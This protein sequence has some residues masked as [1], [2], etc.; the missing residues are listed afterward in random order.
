VE[1]RERRRRDYLFAS[2]DKLM[3]KASE[4][5]VDTMH[6]KTLVMGPP[7]TGKTRFAATWP[8]GNSYFFD[9]DGNMVTVNGAKNVFYDTFKDAD[10][11][12]PTAFQNAQKV[13]VEMVKSV[14]T[15]GYVALM[16]GEAEIKI[17]HVVVDSGSGLLEVVM[18]QV[19]FLGGRAGGVPG[20][21]NQGDSD[22]APQKKG[23]TDFVGSLLALPLAVTL[24]CHEHSKEAESDPIKK[25]YPALT[26]ALATT[27]SSKFQFNF[28]MT[29]IPNAKTKTEEYK[30]LT[31]SQGLYY[32]GHRFGDALDVYEP[33]DWVGILEKLRDYVERRKENE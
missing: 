3:L 24:N 7:L 9:F 11:K 6:P 26:G 2:G 12:R 23:F 13:L 1:D 33:A 21:R 22:W 18:N 10:L 20:T 15:K 25:I 14:A 32:A 4:I 29:V 31:K 5:Q 17:D 16:D 28:R 27:I 19:L 30:L 8:L